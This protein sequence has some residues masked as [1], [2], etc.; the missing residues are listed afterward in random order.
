MI[1]LQG[2]NSLICGVAN[3]RSIAWAIAQRLSEAGANLAITFQSKE[4]QAEAAPLLSTL[5]RVE[6]FVCDVSCDRQLENLYHE[7]KTK[8][9]H[10]NSLV[11]SIAYAPAAD[12]GCDFLAT[13]REGFRIAHDVSAYSLI[14]L[15][16][17]V[18]PL[19]KGGG[20]VMTLSY[21]GAERVVP[22]YKVMGVAKASL[23]ATVRALAYS[24]GKKNIRVNTIS[25]GPIQTRAARGISNFSDIHRAHAEQS[26]MKRNLEPREIADTALYLASD[27]AGA[28]TG[29]TVHVDLGSSVM[30]VGTY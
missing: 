8:Y 29:Q 23:E 20:S 4:I 24:L 19:M 22:V 17:V 15:C 13:S 1:T 26:F 18:T 12:L 9:S 25:A 3:K 2:H 7:L 10:I 6:T 30:P 14:A 5:P 28:I 16:R 11:H 27:L 21:I